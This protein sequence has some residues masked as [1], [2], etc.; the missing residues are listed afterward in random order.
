MHYNYSGYRWHVT[1]ILL[2]ATMACIESVG[3]I[4]VSKGDDHALH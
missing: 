3:L 2:L 1:R 4:N